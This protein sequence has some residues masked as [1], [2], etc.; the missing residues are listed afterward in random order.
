MQWEQRLDRI[1][2]GFGGISQN[3]M[4]EVVGDNGEGMVS[5]ENPGL[6]RSMDADMSIGGTSP[7]IFNST[8]MN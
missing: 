8:N 5:R 3:R 6:E 1:G 7:R 4:D 2:G